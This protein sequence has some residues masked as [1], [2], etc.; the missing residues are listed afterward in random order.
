M[1]LSASQARLLSLTARLSDL[2]L[3][4]QTISNAKIRLSDQSEGASRKYSDALDKQ[5]LKISNLE[6][7]VPLLG[8]HQVENA[9]TAYAG[10]NARGLKIGRTSCVL[11]RKGSKMLQYR[12]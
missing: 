8:I 3:R 4:A 6:F 2:E 7:S 9:A 1:G 5:T 12:F 11:R 10:L